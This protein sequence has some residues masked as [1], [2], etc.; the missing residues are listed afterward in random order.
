MAAAYT[1]LVYDTQ[2]YIHT[3]STYSRWP[4]LPC[5]KSFACSYGVHGI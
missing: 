3:R 1:C 2:A 4:E 5:M